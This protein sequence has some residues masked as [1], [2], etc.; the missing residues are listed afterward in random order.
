MARFFVLV[1]L[2]LVIGGCSQIGSVGA[3]GVAPAAVPEGWSKHSVGSQMSVVLPPYLKK[4]SVPKDSIWS[5]IS[6]LGDSSSLTRV[7]EGPDAK[8]R[9]CMV[10]MTAFHVPAGSSSP[11]GAINEAVDMMSGFG[12]EGVHSSKRKVELPIGPAW[13]GVVTFNFGGEAMSM[14]RYAGEA[15]GRYF[16]VSFM[17]LGAGDTVLVEDEAIMETIRFE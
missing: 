4:D 2:G 7:Y 14:I 17:E 15:S 10:M 5:M 13:R 3:T 1:L 9:D 8:G 6:E 11:E 12:A 16:E